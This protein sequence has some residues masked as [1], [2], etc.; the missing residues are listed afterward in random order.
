MSQRGL[1]GSPPGWR[2]LATYFIDLYLLHCDHPTARVEPVMKQL[3]RHI[4]EGKI[5]AIG[6]SNWSHERIASA[7][8][9]AA[10]KGLKPFSASSVQFSLADWARSLWPGAVTLGGDGQRA[11]RE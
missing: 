5:G 3:N 4:D 9:F 2:K 1:I 7:N 6:A 10:S 11:A 8:T